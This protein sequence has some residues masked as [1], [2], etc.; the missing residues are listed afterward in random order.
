MVNIK[1]IIFVSFSAILVILALVFLQTE[2]SVIGIV[3]EE[4]SGPDWSNITPREVIK[5]SFLVIVLESINEKDCKLKA[6]EISAVLTH[7]DFKKSEEFARKV[8]Y[9]NEDNTIILPCE[10][11]SGEKL[12]FNIW[13]ITEDA[14]NHATKYTY[15]L[16]ESSSD[17]MIKGFDE[18]P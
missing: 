17:S 9:N 18:P 6:G 2:D 5:T 3:V 13:Y 4:L 14:K 1:G 12:K 11:L 10:S 8:Q 7:A 16:S 15:W